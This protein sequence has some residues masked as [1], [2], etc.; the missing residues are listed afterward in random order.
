MVKA[1]SVGRDAKNEIVL[2]DRTVSRRHGTLEL[3]ED[4]STYFHDTDSSN[5][6]FFIQEGDLVPV[7]G[8]DLNEADLLLLGGFEIEVGALIDM[9]Q[10]PELNARVEN[11]PAGAGQLHVKV[12]GTPRGVGGSGARVRR[13]PKTGKIVRET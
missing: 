2:Q 13:D 10:E 9:A 5:G 7:D 3:S 4:G 12:T 8:I 6:S 11:A 1:F